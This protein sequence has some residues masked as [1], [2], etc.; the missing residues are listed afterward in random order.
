MSDSG[1]EFEDEYDGSEFHIRSRKI[2]G[3]SVT[4]GMIVFL[5]DRGLAKNEKQAFT[6]SLVLIGIFL[7]TSIFIIRTTLVNDKPIQ[8]VDKYGRV[9][10]YDEYVVQLKKGI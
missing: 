9:I 1:V 6:I 10:T 5:M 3:E 2:L 7:I 8:I 4:P